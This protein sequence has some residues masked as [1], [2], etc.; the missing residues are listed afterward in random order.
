MRSHLFHLMCKL[1]KHHHAHLPAGVLLPL[2]SPQVTPKNWLMLICHLSAGIK[3]LASRILG[4]Q[5]TLP[6][7]SLSA[8]N[9]IPLGIHQVL[10]QRPLKFEVGLV[11]M[12]S[13]CQVLRHSSQH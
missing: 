5:K 6:K 10:H 2:A 11:E 9:E 7:Y 8:R 1:A 13:Q 4:T 12:H 3:H